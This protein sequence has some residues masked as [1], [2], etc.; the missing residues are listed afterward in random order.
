MSYNIPLL[1][2]A[3][4]ST[5]TILGQ[6]G[7][8]ASTA[9]TSSSGSGSATPS[10]SSG[11]S[12]TG[13]VYYL[14]YKQH[15]QYATARTETY[16]FKRSDLS[17]IKN[18]LG[19]D[20][21]AFK[22]ISATFILDRSIDN[23][24][25]RTYKNIQQFDIRSFTTQ[26]TS[27]NGLSPKDSSTGNI[28]PL[29]PND[30]AVTITVLYYDSIPRYWEVERN[31][32]IFK[33]SR[34]RLAITQDSAILKNRPYYI[35][36]DYYLIKHTT[37]IT[38]P[39]YQPLVTG[40][41][42]TNTTHEHNLVRPLY[43]ETPT[44]AFDS[45]Y[46]GLLVEY[47][48]R[49]FEYNADLFSATIDHFNKKTENDAFT[50]KYR[51]IVSLY[52]PLR[53]KYDSLVNN[54][55]TNLEDAWSAAHNPGQIQDSL[56]NNVAF[57]NQLFSLATSKDS[58]PPALPDNI[59]SKE[60][61]E[62][63]IA[64]SADD[65]ANNLYFSII[66]KKTLSQSMYYRSFHYG[67]WD[68]G[69]A[70]IPFRIRF[71]QPKKT[72]YTTSGKTA[73]TASAP[74]ESDGTFNVS[75]YLGRKWGHTRFYE[76]PSMTTNTVAVEAALV[77]GPTLIAL[78]NSNID[79]TSKYS[80]YKNGSNYVGPEN[81]VAWSTAVGGVLQWKVI[82]VGFYAGADIP[83]TPHTGWVYAHQL[84]IGFGIGVNLGMFSSNNSVN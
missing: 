17:T 19:I 36:S 76:D 64:L 42:P 67:T 11:T 47:R 27:N 72:I 59:L 9:T 74:S 35:N 20:S 4:L 39:T 79:T 16:Y 69:T 53:A 51:S 48:M 49:I 13:Y 24:V 18:I 46:K 22:T 60:I 12:Q 75:G 71:A 7:K 10:S 45:T 50:N 66:Q 73:T 37:K 63:A 14:K 40:V 57:I 80:G 77:T 26:V 8:G 58:V 25:G 2:I 21:P 38:N 31:S 1:L 54:Q 65:S 56:V 81:I 5:T 70:T 28:K 33:K 84:W 61:Y 6:H 23:A 30:T 43:S 78:S 3:I 68:Y 52:T 55:K 41:I 32:N 82:S 62:T 29:N 44:R 34:L 15:I 83:L